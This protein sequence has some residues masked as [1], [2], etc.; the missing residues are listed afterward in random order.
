LG[1]FFTFMSSAI[2]PSVPLIMSEDRL[3]DLNFLVLL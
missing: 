1:I 2:F 3:G